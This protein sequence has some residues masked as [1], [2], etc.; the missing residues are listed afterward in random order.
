MELQ[1]AIIKGDLN[2]LRRLEHQILEHVN[3][4]YEDAGN[5]NDDYENFSIYWITGQKDKNLALD[6]L[7]VFLNT[8]QTALGDYFQEYMDVMVYPGLV[9][10]VCAENQA[11][12]DILK[13][14]ADEHTY[15][16]IFT[17]YN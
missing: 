6:M 10:A 12:I 14:F 16:D 3:H 9:G 11:I 1:R 7:M 2:G 15:M 17:T 4:V 8:C 5:G 13:T